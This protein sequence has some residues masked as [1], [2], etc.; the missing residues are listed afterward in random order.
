QGADVA[1]AS[2]R[3]GISP[4]SGVGI[5][6][7]DSDGDPVDFFGVS[8]FYTSGGV[9]FNDGFLLT[10]LADDGKL[11]LYYH[12]RLDEDPEITL[13]EYSFMD[14][15]L[16]DDDAILGTWFGSQ[17]PSFYRIN[18]DLEVLWER[19]IPG[20]DIGA[21]VMLDHK[22]SVIACAGKRVYEDT[23]SRVFAL[24]KTTGETLWE[25]EI[26]VFIN[27]LEL[28][29]DRIYISSQTDRSYLV[30]NAD[31]GA[32]LLS[33]HEQGKGKFDFKWLWEDSGYLF[34]YYTASVI[35]VLDGATG[36]I[37]QDV[38]IPAEFAL[39]TRRPLVRNDHI[40]FPLLPGGGLHRADCY[41]GVMVLPREE[42]K[43]GFPLSIEIEDKGD[44]SYQAVADGKTEYYE[45]SASY[46]ELGDVLRF[47]QIEVRL[48]AQKY[49]YNFWGNM[50][51]NFKARLNK[52]FN[53][54][55]VLNVDR[56]RLKNPDER[57]FDLM[58][59]LFN[60]HFKENSL[61]PATK[62]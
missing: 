31:T 37:V 2:I 16:I 55:I 20:K 36:N 44:I 49:A 41:G 59:E 38:E 51:D 18:K 52:K 54:R 22:H 40:Y 35:R 10:H 60:E 26:P 6:Y 21:E 27:Y 7:L 5:V 56:A 50:E 1:V 19:R 39:S 34:V 62:K 3:T 4:K 29:D 33:K 24:D 9:V 43:Q 53:G 23:T 57:K 8:E 48:V 32:I 25:T 11:S 17:E 58:V 30:L 14:H 12:K 28:I 46:E 47:G 45:I 61:A 42:L 15:V 13:P